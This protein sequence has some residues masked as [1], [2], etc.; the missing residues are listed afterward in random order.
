MERN[1][2]FE[3]VAGFDYGALNNPEFKE[4]SV[5]EEIIMPLMKALGYDYKGRYQI[6]RS[7]KLRH[8]FFMVGSNKYNISV[9]PDYILEC[10]GVCVCTLEAKSPPV[11]LDDGTCIGQA[12]SYAVHREVRAKFYALCNGREFRL[13]ATSSLT[14]VIIFQMQYLTSHFD[15]LNAIMGAERISLYA[16]RRFAKDLGIH[17]KMLTMGI[18]EQRF[19]FM[20]F[21]IYQITLVE[22]DNYTVDATITL[23]GERY[24]GSFD[25]DYAALSGLKNVLSEEILA[26][27]R[28]PFTGTPV[29]VELCGKI[30]QTGISCK[31]G[32]KIYENANEHYMPFRICEFIYAELK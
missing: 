31:L 17:L 29:R 20:D 12:Y 7:R 30:I 27:L 11:S 4:D 32:E 9:F 26:T 22:P 25:F 15:R 14:P 24:C 21:P 13:Y 3:E 5:R 18:S 8:P 2:W 16:E 6:V 19:T 23:D 28:E 10:D 1:R